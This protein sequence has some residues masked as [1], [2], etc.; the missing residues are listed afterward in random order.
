MSQDYNLVPLEVLSLLSP[1]LGEVGLCSG[2]ELLGGR[3]IWR[4][5]GLALPYFLYSHS[6]VWSDGLQGGL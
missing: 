4:W 3:G 5:S 2:E 6:E 1:S